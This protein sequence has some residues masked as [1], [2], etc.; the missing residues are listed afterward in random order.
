MKKKNEEE[1][2]EEN[3]DFYKNKKVYELKKLCKQ[4]GIK[5]SGKKS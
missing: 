4:K 5:S 3:E 1:N 2:E